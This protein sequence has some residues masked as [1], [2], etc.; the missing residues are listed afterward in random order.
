M[1]PEQKVPAALYAIH[2]ILIKLRFTALTEG[3]EN[4]KL[5]KILDWT[6]ILP[7]LIT[8]QEDRDTTEE[9]REMLKGLGEEFPESAGILTNFDR[10]LSWDRAL[11][12][13]AART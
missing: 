3:I 10:N 9:F 12:T 13:A 5:S 4:Q 1:L 2:T 11:T 7:T 8:R 6:E